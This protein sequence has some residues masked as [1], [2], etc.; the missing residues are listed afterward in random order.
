[1]KPS[2]VDDIAKAIARAVGAIRPEIEDLLKKGDFVTLRARVG[3][4]MDE[5]IGRYEPVKRGP[6]GAH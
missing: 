3:D 5:V 6:P 1:M 4:L 2:T